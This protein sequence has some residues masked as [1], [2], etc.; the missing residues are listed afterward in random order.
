MGFHRTQYSAILPKKVARR[1]EQNLVLYPSNPIKELDFIGNERLV[2]RLERNGKYKVEKYPEMPLSLRISG[3]LNPLYFQHELVLFKGEPNV[4]CITTR[5]YGCNF[6]FICFLQPMGD[7][8]ITY[9]KKQTS[10]KLWN[11]TSGVMVRLYNG[12]KKQ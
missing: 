3:A 1:V 12:Y 5:S 2:V 4:E 8:F 9:G 10:F 11:K 7:V 6:D